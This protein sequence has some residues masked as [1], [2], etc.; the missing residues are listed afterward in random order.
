MRKR[1]VSVEMQGGKFDPR[2]YKPL[3]KKENEQEK[4]SENV[5]HDRKKSER[6]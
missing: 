3:E 4:S 5:G 2:E 1:S 6:R